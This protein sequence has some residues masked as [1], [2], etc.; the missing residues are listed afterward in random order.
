MGD[1]GAIAGWA[2][3]DSWEDREM[4]G[5]ERAKKGGRGE[6]ERLDAISGAYKVAVNGDV[7]RCILRRFVGLLLARSGS[8]CSWWSR[9]ESVLE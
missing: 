7:A 3:R 1:V 6:D 8:S 5:K 9:L 4:G 2:P